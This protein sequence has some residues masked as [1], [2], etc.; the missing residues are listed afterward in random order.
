[1][2]PTNRTGDSPAVVTL[3]SDPSDPKIPVA[4]FDNQGTP[5]KPVTWIDRGTLSALD[6]ERYWA[7]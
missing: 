7:A 2:W 3:R 4:P 5:R 6:Y 1:M